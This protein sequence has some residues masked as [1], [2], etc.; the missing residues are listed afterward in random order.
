MPEITWT[1][2][3]CGDERPDSAI[4]VFRTDVSAENGLPAGTMQQNVRYCNDRPVCTKGATTHRLFKPATKGTH[5]QK[6]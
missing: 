4:S 6:Y 1:C 2:R 5:A 3:I